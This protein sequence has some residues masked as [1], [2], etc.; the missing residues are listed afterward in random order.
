MLLGTS[1]IARCGLSK[2]WLLSLRM[3]V[4]W[5]RM[6]FR[7]IGPR[8]I[9]NARRSRTRSGIC[10]FKGSN[11]QLLDRYSIFYQGR[12]GLVRSIGWNRAMKRWRKKCVGRFEEIDH[13]CRR[14][15]RRRWSW[16]ISFWRHSCAKYHFLVIN[17]GLKIL[18]P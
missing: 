15:K 5:V 2:P 7:R 10:E 1:S 4:V 9:S 18:L 3:V 6:R 14:Y 11:F 8:F 17:P 16:R 12:R 13:M